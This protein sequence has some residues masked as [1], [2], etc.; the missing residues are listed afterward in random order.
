MTLDEIDKFF[1]ETKK[2]IFP[3]INTPVNGKSYRDK[4]MKWEVLR[5][6]GVKYGIQ[7]C[8]YF[9][10]GHVDDYRIVVEAPREIWRVEC[11]LNVEF[12]NPIFDLPPGVPPGN[13]RGPHQLTWYNNRLLYQAGQKATR[14]RYAEPLSK[15]LDFNAVIDWLLPMMNIIVP[16]WSLKPRGLL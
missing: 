12:D 16:S 5:P 11:G 1:A 9:T 15:N 4:V 7:L 14:L 13:I 10:P 2:S 6:T 8:V 3:Q